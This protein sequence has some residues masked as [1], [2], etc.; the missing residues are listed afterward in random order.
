M[1]RN[2]RRNEQVR[3]NDGARRPAAARLGGHPTRPD[4]VG[5]DRIVGP[6]LELLISPWSLR[7][8][9]RLLKGATLTGCGLRSLVR[10]MIYYLSGIAR[11]S[12]GAAISPRTTSL[13]R[14]RGHVTGHER[15]LVARINRH[16]A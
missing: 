14:R 6:A 11:G 9:H 4:A 15:V 2:L 13:R 1:G 8:S 16:R 12:Q 7:N 10:S 5:R 3:G